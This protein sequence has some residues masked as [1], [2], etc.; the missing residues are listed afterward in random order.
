VSDQIGDVV[1]AG[2]ELAAVVAYGR[3]IP[4]HVLDQVPMVNL[5]FSLLPRWRGAAPVERAILA[6]DEVT[7][8]C[9]M[10]IDEGLDTGA[11]YAREEVAIGVGEH[12]SALRARL[13]DV[14]SALLVKT[15]A[16]GAAGLPTPV[17]QT[18]ETTYAEK[19]GPQEYELH[20]DRPA[21]ELLRVVR[22]DR[23][24]TTF[25]GR[26]LRVLEAGASDAP[27]QAGVLAGAVVG[28]GE[29]A[30]ELRRVQPEG[31]AAMAAEEWLRGAR[32]EAGER[33][34]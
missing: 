11:V 9:A 33:L 31:R 1:D 18:G 29:G 4:A 17:P 30:L 16:G 10:A 27:A 22:L 28:A 23:A 19:V 25:R 6:G 20:W 3:I 32:V 24:W 15:V 21:A 2:V 14:G 5:H 7:G 26:R 8:V 12:L 13:V 34:G